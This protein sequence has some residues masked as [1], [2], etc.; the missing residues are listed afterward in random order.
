MKR[1]L[2]FAPRDKRGISARARSAAGGADPS[3]ARKPRCARAKRILFITDLTG[4]GGGETYLLYFTR[5]L[6]AAGRFVPVVGAFAEGPLTGALRA[7]GVEVL[8]LPDVTLRR[9]AGL[10]PVFS[11]LK[12]ARFVFRL[13]R[14]RVALVQLEQFNNRTFA[15]A[16][17]ARLAGAPVV[18]RSH[19]WSAPVKR[20][21]R[22]YV[23]CFFSVV[24][25]VSR[26][27]K[28][29]LE[30]SGVRPRRVETI[31]CG[32]AVS[33]F[34]PSA[35][36]A[37]LRTRLNLA[38]DTFALGMIARFQRVKGHHV[39][40]DA[41]AELIGAGLD[42]H[43]FIVGGVAHGRAED[44][45]CREEILRTI[46]ER[47]LESRLTLTGFVPDVRDV[48]HALDA[49]VVPSLSESFGMVV[50]ESM[51]SGVPVVAT[52]CGGP[53][54]II[55]DGVTGFLV[56]VNDPAALAGVIQRL[57]RDPSLR[58]GVAARAADHVRR[59]FSIEKNVADL[60]ALYDSL[61]K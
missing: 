57:A 5:A 37:E 9:A 38:P 60:S 17:L 22:W 35:P 45:R 14:R 20:Y 18:L 41:V 50:I 19:L 55:A 54:E 16:P 2:F 27:V 40:L 21:V 31:P 3:A 4:L 56:P 52:R 51:A 46:R 23:R 34:A 24:L 48:L 33:E 29:M 25:P 49:V 39:F 59:F 26:N 1:N 58:R 53:E 6:A 32:V 44:E 10:V 28:N 12:F 42:F 43:A 30:R 13:K 61:L 47:R 15:A 36:A 7:A 8:V 11:P